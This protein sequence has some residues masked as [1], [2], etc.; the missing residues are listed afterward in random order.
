MKDIDKLVSN[1]KC[2][3]CDW[4]GYDPDDMYFPCYDS[5]DE[6]REYPFK[7]CPTCKTDHYLMDI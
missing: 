5:D 1:V 7:G 4:F 6:N 3:N 2:C